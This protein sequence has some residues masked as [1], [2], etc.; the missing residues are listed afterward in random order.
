MK[1]VGTNTSFYT[2]NLAAADNFALRVSKV[3]GTILRSS[4]VQYCSI[5]GKYCGILHHHQDVDCLRF[6]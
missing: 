4:I 5:T 3:A 6:G 1:V 2:T